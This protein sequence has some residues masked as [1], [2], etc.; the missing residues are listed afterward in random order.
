VTKVVRRLER[1]RADS[2]ERE[3]FVLNLVAALG[4]WDAAQREWNQTVGDM[5]QAPEARRQL[6]RAEAMA[7]TAIAALLKARNL[8]RDDIP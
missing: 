8:W 1:V 6:S 3:R 7:I 5:L 4:S 2:A